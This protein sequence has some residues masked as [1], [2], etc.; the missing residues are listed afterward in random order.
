MKTL[1]LYQTQNHMGLAD[2]RL[3][4]HKMIDTV[5]DSEKLSAV[6]TL[7]KSSSSPFKAMTLDEYVG[8]IDTARAQI[9]EGKYLTQEELEKQVENW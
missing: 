5:E 8:A 7:L 9:K 2:I 6:Y 1:T 3:Q 4:L